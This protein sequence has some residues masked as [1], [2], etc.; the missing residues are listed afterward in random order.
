[1][2]RSRPRFRSGFTL[3]ELLVVIA[4]IAVLIGL[5]LPAV[6]KVRTAAARIQSMNNLR[7]IGLAIH[8]FENVRNKL[9]FNGDG[10][11]FG[12]GS[13]LRWADPADPVNG[14]NRGSWAF[15]IL[16]YIEQD[17]F[18]RSRA[19]LGN[20]AWGN[21]PSKSVALKT[22]LCPVRGR[23]GF[24]TTGGR[25]GPYTDYVLNCWL[26]APT[27][28]AEWVVD[29]RA[30]LSSIT[31]GTSNTFLAG[32]RVVHPRDYQSTSDFWN[33]TILFSGS[34]GTGLG[35]N[36][37]GFFSDR[38]GQELFIAAGSPT[39]FPASST[40]RASWGSP[41]EDGSFFVMCDASVRSVRYGTDLANGLNPRDGNATTG[42]D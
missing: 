32:Y 3:I 6:Q 19:G 11:N 40:G 22:F 23:P 42:L 5:L 41:F 14:D 2:S 20:N 12:T 31:D 26:N 4:I 38:R 21:T 18:H 29:A 36:R 25:A 7:Q 17:N 27:N 37:L 9:P 13:V 35:T 28:G 8:N 30:K 24:S 10:Q 16:P 33:E 1:M 39:A 15:H 34:W